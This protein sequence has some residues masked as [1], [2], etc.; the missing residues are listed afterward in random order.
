VFERFTQQ[1]RQVVTSAQHEARGLRHDYIGTEHLLLGLL[2]EPEGVAAEVMRDL[3]IHADEARAQVV[4]LV[5]RGKAPTAN[6]G[7][8][9]FTPRA[10]R[11]LELALREALQLGDG[12]VGAEHVLLGLARLNEGIGPVI[13]VGAGATAPRVA[14]AVVEA[15]GGE[16]PRGYIEGFSEEEPSAAKVVATERTGLLLFGW[17]VFLLAFGLGILLGW[18]VWGL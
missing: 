13:L 11:T 2:R 12:H 5:G 3:S 14:A 1:A 16:A 4:Q 8:V 15:R 7:H 17:L 18:L 6:G 9:P 10:K